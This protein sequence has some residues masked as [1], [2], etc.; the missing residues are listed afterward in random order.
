MGKKRSLCQDRLGTNIRRIEQKRSL[1]CF[2][3]WGQGRWKAHWATG[4]GLGGCSQHSCKK[5]EYPLRA[6]QVSSESCNLPQHLDLFMT[7]SLLPRSRY[8]LDAPLLFDVVADPSEAYP[9]HGMI[10]AS[11]SPEAGTARLPCNGA[12]FTTFLS[13]YITQKE[14]IYQ[15]RLGTNI[16]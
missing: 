9:L 2:G 5:L 10:N 4:P 8:P 7:C 1:L 14:S 16:Q 12:E 6:I 15:D 13:H 3:L 11:A